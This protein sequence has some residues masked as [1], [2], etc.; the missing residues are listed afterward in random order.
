MSETCDM[1]N[2]DGT[3]V[4]RLGEDGIEVFVSSERCFSMPW[5]WID[6]V[7]ASLISSEKEEFEIPETQ[8]GEWPE[9]ER[10]QA[11]SGLKG[12]SQF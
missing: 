8:Y 4:C 11:E 7:R 5:P 1:S 9:V 12:Y 3:V 6:Q 10:P 2:P